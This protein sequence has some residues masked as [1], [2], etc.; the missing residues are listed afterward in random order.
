MK[1]IN[2]K[3]LVLFFILIILQGCSSGGREDRLE[4]RNFFQVGAY[5]QG[6]QFL[7]KSKFYQDKDERL[8]ALMERGML[9]HSKGEWEKSSQVL[10]E[11]RSLST[12]LYTISLSK[13]AEKTL[14][15]DNY[16]QFYGEIYERSL[17]H[18]YLSLNAILNY[19]KTQKRDDLFRARAEVLAWDSFLSSIKEDRLGKSVYK[20]DLLLKIYG[21]KIHEMVGTREDRQI[22]LQLFKDARDVIFKNYNTYPSFNK[23]YKEFKKDF[24]SLSSKSIEEVKKNYISESD[25][26]KNILDYINENINRLSKKEGKN[27]SKEGKT[28]VT[29]ILEKGMIA[30]K[31][32]EK[33]FYGLDFLAKEPLVAFFA[34]DVLGLLPAAH[35]YNPGGAFMGV[36]VASAA[37]QSVGVGFELPKVLNTNSPGKQTLIVFDKNNKEV[38]TK[39]ISLVNPLSDIAE[40]AI[41]EASAWNY[42]RVGIRLATKHATAIAAS[43]ATYKA[44]G[45]GKNSNENFLAK[46][47]AVIQYVGAAK[48]IEE[49]EKADTRYWSTLPNEIRLVDL[50]LA[51]GHYRLELILNSEQKMSLGEVEV[52]AQ[53]LPQLFNFRKF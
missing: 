34:A 18:F 11:A 52:V 22:A 15:N 48:L 49:S 3:V 10:D 26:Q 31:V 5:D 14:L 46:N 23:N 30:E 41:Y 7:E 17:L 50:L 42:A 12:Q 51:P 37:L 28:S 47:A 9:L 35:S 29:V 6:L 21:A 39:D 24:E 32:A 36:F 1:K 33:S 43:F 53:E 25:H 4:L 2:E 38:L 20:N 27:H 16:D 19:Q 13:K 8:L 44:L 40:E 45:G